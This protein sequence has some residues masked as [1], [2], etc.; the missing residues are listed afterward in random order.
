MGIMVGFVG[1][2]LL[3]PRPCVRG[4]GNRCVVRAGVRENVSRVGGLIAAAVLSGFGSSASVN[5]AQREIHLLEMNRERTEL[6]ADGR[7]EILDGKKE[8]E[9]PSREA[10]HFGGSVCVTNLTLFLVWGLSLD[11]WG[12][13]YKEK[14]PR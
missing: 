13:H 14:T 6:V 3:M 4:K 12:S 8:D 1:N 2:G 5:A 11:R 9:E 7:A 10:F